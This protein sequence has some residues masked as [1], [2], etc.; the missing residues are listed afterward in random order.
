MIQMLL[1]LVLMAF[2][3]SC[4]SQQCTGIPIN[5]EEFNNSVRKINNLYSSQK[6]ENTEDYILSVRIANTLVIRGLLEESEEYKFFYEN[7][8][9]KFLMQTVNALGAK[10]SK[11]MSYYSRKYDL[12]IGG[13]AHSNSI[14][15]LK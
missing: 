2:E 1:I 11:G 9:E 13:E 10:L 5:T 3:P 4:G 8:T 7:F 15:C 6:I 12:N 14:F